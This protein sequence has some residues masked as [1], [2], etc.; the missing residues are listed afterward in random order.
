MLTE[1]DATTIQ[2]RITRNEQVGDN[3]VIDSSTTSSEMVRHAFRL[4]KQDAYYDKMDLF[5]RANIAEYEAGGAFVSRLDTLALVLDELRKDSP[6]PMSEVAIK[7]WLEQVDF[8]LLPKSVEFPMPPK[9]SND[10]AAQSARLISN[11]R[12]AERYIIKQDGGV[13]YFIYAPVELYILSTLWCMLVGVDLDYALDVGCLGNRL[14]IDSQGVFTLPRGRRVLFVWGS[15][16]HV[17]A[18][19]QR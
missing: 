13:Q 19:H 17:E 10:S 18:S 3:T 4:L 7:K 1:P 6:S 11:M 8:R 5:L 16:L 9:S 15:C 2:M 14:E 12:T